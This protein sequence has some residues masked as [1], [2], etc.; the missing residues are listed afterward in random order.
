MIPLKEEYRHVQRYSGVALGI[1][2]SRRRPKALW[3]DGADVSPHVI[4]EPSG[5]VADVSDRMDVLHGGVEE[6]KGA[7]PNDKLEIALVELQK[8]SEV[9]W[10]LHCP[11]HASDVPIGM[12]KISL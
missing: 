2:G 6:Q 4:E 11:K 3:N 7:V 10:C 9:S 12:Q 8:T 1:R 5:T